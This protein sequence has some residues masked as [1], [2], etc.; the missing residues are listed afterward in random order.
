MCGGSHQINDAQVELH[1][2]NVDLLVEFNNGV[3]VNQV[4][5]E[6]KPWST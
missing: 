5:F 2:N 3:N 4:L 1:K 6:N